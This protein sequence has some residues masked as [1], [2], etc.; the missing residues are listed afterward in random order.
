M[1]T[2][3]H[4]FEHPEHL[5]RAAHWIYDE[6]WATTNVHTPDSLA[7]YFRQATRADAI[8][9]SLLAFWDGEPA[10]TINLIENDDDKRRHLRPWLAAL[11]VAPGHRH[12]GIG[13]TLVRTLQQHAAALG[14]ATLYLGTDNPGFYTRLG[15]TLHEQVD[16]KFAVMQ[17]G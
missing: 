2:I 3:A 1:L 5:D 9:L 13:S 10:G 6:F 8:P 4:L 7:G 15:A 17:L 12:R 11:Y 14:I 16:E